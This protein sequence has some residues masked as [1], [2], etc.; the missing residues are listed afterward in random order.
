MLRG[1]VTHHAVHVCGGDPA[2]CTLPDLEAGWTIGPGRCRWE[3]TYTG[4]NWCSC[5]MCHW[6]H[7]PQERRGA[8]RA[9]LRGV[10]REWNA[11][12]REG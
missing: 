1:E 3:W 11:S 10:A 7:R 6:R 8:V 9:D 4:Q 5:W 2:R 12:G